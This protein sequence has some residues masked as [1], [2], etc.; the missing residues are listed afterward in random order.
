MELTGGCQK[1]SINNYAS[2]LS[3]WY[4][5]V[6]NEVC[7]HFL[8]QIFKSLIFASFVLPVP[9]T[10]VTFL[11]PSLL[12][13]PPPL[14]LPVPHYGFSFLLAV[15]FSFPRFFIII[16]LF[17][18]YASLSCLLAFPNVCLPFLSLFPSCFSIYFP[19]HVF[20][21]PP[22][23]PSSGFKLRHSSSLSSFFLVGCITLSF[24]LLLIRCTSL[25]LLLSSFSFHSR[26]PCHAC[27]RSLYVSFSSSFLACPSALSA[28]RSVRP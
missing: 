12:L 6:V 19:S 5:G 1:S 15:S 23:P 21:G 27:C 11:L 28:C 9:L 10:S 22:L 18:L 3:L 20:L 14:S 26:S 4:S 17:L 24:T 16:F 2:S 25:L 7:S 13:F 8:F